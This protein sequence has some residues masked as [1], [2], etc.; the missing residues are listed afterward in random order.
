MLR[1]TSRL[2]YQAFSTWLHS[3][4]SDRN[5]F[6]SLG[7]NHNTQYFY[8]IYVFS[9]TS[10]H[11]WHGLRLPSY[12]VACMSLPI[13]AAAEPTTQSQ[14]GSISDHSLPI[15]QC[16]RLVTHKHTF[17]ADPF[18]I[19]IS[20]AGLV[21]LGIQLLQGLNQY[22]GS[23]LDS[24]GRIKAISTDIDLT[25]QIVKA[26]DTTIQ[27]DANKAM[28]TNDAARLAIET[29][30]QC[31]DVFAK[32]QSTLSE[33][34]AT[35]PRRRDVITWPFIEPKLDILRGNL[36]KLKTSLQLLMS[37]IIFAAM[38]KRSVCSVSCAVLIQPSDQ[39]ILDILNNPSWI[40]SDSRLTSS[41]RKKQQLKLGWRL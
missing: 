14:H 39:F 33:Y 18:T 21:S 15:C 4:E 25:I 19:A 13:H 38:S 35:G 1:W 32:I 8:Y 30:A 26:L 2:F 17:M 40:N 20:T 31:R 22:A 16:F 28:M 34:S 9:P 10:P 41:S 29:I 5:C 24:K 3:L 27:D 36:E 6:C 37:V 23:A 11:S 7:K 12:V